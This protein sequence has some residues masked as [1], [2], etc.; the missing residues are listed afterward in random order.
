LQPD[1]L[2][3]LVCAAYIP[4]F[5]K[6]YGLGAIPDVKFFRHFVPWTSICGLPFSAANVFLG[7]QAESLSG[8]AVREGR[9]R[10]K[11]D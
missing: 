2:T 7:L 5:I 10:R 9:E 3:A 4:A 11:G 1:L 6:N 8:E